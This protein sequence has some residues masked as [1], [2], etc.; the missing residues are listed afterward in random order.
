[1]T[2]PLIGGLSELADGYDAYLLD[3]W[4]V[5][6]DGLTLYPGALD[7][8]AK[9]RGAGKHLLLV[10]NASRRAVVVGG[11]LGALGVP[12]GYFDAVVTSGEGCWQAMQ[13]GR[14]GRRCYY[15]GPGYSLNLFDGLKVTRVEELTLADFVLVAGMAQRTDTPDAYDD[16]LMQASELGL[17]LVCANSDI[18]VIHSG[19]RRYSGGAVA[20]RFE[21]L[22]GTVHYFGKPRR[23]IFESCVA[24]I[25]EIP[26]ERILVV[27]D[28]FDTDIPGAIDAGLDSLFIAGGIHAE[29]LGGRPF[30]AENLETFYARRGLRPTAS[31]D[32]LRW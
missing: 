13:S 23:A 18:E 29:E 11:E 14:Y 12:I 31:L 27:G 24:R 22:G 1:M 8:L 19:E 2:A 32:V 25:A 7:C 6:H 10:S 28:S 16:L 30:S 15:L 26:R 3:A 5:I 17:E 21:M 9:L 4:G 20:R